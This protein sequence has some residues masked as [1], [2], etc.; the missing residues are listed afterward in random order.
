MAYSQGSVYLW[1]KIYNASY[2]SGNTKL[3]IVR[4]ART[5]KQECFRKNKMK[6]YIPF[7]IKRILNFYKLLHLIHITKISSKK[8]IPPIWNRLPRYPKTIHRFHLTVAACGQ[9]Y[10][11]CQPDP[12]CI[13]KHV[14]E[15]HRS[16][17][18]S[19][20][21]LDVL[22]VCTEPCSVC[23]FMSTERHR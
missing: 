19:H 12:R 4:S 23:A 5:I 7:R 1:T 22:D 15:V 16:G 8:Y 17:R 13:A 9:G 18:G 10:I 3:Y 6:I 14:P 2:L 20:T 11:S 21:V